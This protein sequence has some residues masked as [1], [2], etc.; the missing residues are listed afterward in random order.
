MD[1]CRIQPVSGCRP[2]SGRCWYPVDV[3]SDN[4][5]PDEALL[6]PERLL[7]DVPRG[8]PEY[9]LARLRPSAVALLQGPLLREEKVRLLTSR[10]RDR[11]ARAEHKKGAQQPLRTFFIALQPYGRPDY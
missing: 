8:L 3:T 4:G 10:S 11:A 2:N 5:R 6:R 9:L 7:R 1:E